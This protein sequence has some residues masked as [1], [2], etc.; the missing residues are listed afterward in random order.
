MLELR[1][2]NQKGNSSFPGTNLGRFLAQRGVL[3]LKEGRLIEVIWGEF[4]HKINVETWIIATARGKQAG[5]SFGIRFENIGEENR[6]LGSG[7][8]DCDEIGELVGALAYIQELANSIAGQDRD[9]T[10]VI[11]SSKDNIRIGFFQKSKVDQQ[12][13]FDA[14]GNGKAVYLN[15]ERLAVLKGALVT[16]RDHLVSRGAVV[17]AD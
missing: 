6:T 12:A 8:L 10:E 17:E 13:F 2:D 7:F 1:A 9:Y 3:L 14:G 15:F 11:Y 4:R 5:Q 16:A